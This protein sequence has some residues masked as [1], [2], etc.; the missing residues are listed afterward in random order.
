MI[1]HVCEL[2]E[3]STHLL[4]D[5]LSDL[6]VKELRWPSTEGD[7]WNGLNVTSSR[8]HNPTE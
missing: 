6:D 4:L 5:F 3:D 7:I 2:P 1:A 8:E